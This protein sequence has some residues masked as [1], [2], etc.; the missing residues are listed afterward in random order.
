MEHNYEIENGGLHLCNSIK[1]KCAVYLSYIYRFCIIIL[2]ISSLLFSMYITL[3]IYEKCITDITL[4]ECIPLGSI[5]ATFGSAV[6]SVASVYCSEQNSLFQENLAILRKQIP[7]LDSW[8]RWPFLKR[9]TREKISFFQN[10]YY[11]LL[12]PQITFKVNARNLSIPLPSCTADFKD[13]PVIINVMKM[14]CFRK[15][16][17]SFIYSLHNIKKLEDLYIFDCIL[18]IYKNIIKYK[19]STA[20]IWV[21]GEFIF[22]SI[23][24]SF[25]YEPITSFL[26]YLATYF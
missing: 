8:E 9:Y 6:I 24:F 25:F 20:F 17:L 16:Y 14:D 1:N 26:K 22:S 15:H 11:I 18:M 4:K 7:D 12:N 23:L 13:L 21:G 2:E 3:I 5:F 10:N 19:W